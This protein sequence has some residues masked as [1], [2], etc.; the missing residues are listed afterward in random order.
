MGSVSSPTLHVGLY[1]YT[2]D[3]LQLDGQWPEQLELW[4]DTPLWIPEW[5]A[6]LNGHPD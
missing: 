6:L 2:A 4:V 1:P 5:E 3:F